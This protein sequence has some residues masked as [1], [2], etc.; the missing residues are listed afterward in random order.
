MISEI[1]FKIKYPVFMVNQIYNFLNI[2]TL[3]SRES[4]IKKDIKKQVFSLC[5]NVF[6]FE[7][8]KIKNIRE[9]RIVPIQNNKFV[10][11]I[12]NIDRSEEE[13]EIS[14]TEINKKQLNQI[15]NLLKLN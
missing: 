2:F 15:A 10:F 3:E 7:T 6:N 4:S 13:L 14:S 5:R 11:E 1:R 9:F 8:E 12:T